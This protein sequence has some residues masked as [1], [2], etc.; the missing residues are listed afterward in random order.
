MRLESPLCKVRL[1]S[2]NAP[3]AWGFFALLCLWVGC[4]PSEKTQDDQPSS[5]TVGRA[6]EWRVEASASSSAPTPGSVSIER[7]SAVKLWRQ[8]P[9][10]LN[11][12]TVAKSFFPEFFWSEGPTAQGISLPAIQDSLRVHLP[13]SADG[14]LAL[15]AGP[16]FFQLRSIESSNPSAS[17]KLGRGLFYSS[18][19]F[20]LAA[21]GTGGSD[22]DSHWQTSRVDEFVIHEGAHT[23]FSTRYEVKLSQTVRSVRDTGRWLEF[24]DADGI[25]VLRM[26]Y[27]LAR[28]L[29]GLTHQGTATLRGVVP[30]KLDAD[31]A[32]IYRLSAS[33]L[34]VELTVP[35]AGMQSPVLITTSLTSPVNMAYPRTQHTAT[36]LPSGKVLVAGGYS[37]TGS[38]QEIDLYDPVTRTW[39][40]ATS[41]GVP[42]RNHTATLLPSGKVLFVGGVAP[43]TTPLDTAE[44]YNPAPGIAQ[45]STPVGTQDT[46][47]ATHTATLL[48]NGGVLITGGVKGGV[49]K[50]T[51]LYPP[52]GGNWES[53]GDLTTARALHTATLLQSGKVLVIGGI[54]HGSNKLNSA[55]LYNPNT[56]GWESFPSI[57]TSRSEHTAVL[58]ASDTVLVIGGIG[59]ANNSVLSSCEM[60]D[61]Q[62][63][64]AQWASAAPLST[65]RSGHIATLL[66][67]SKVLITG[68]INSTGAPVSNVTLYDPATGEAAVSTTPALTPRYGHTATLLPSGEVLVAGGQGLTGSLQ[69]SQTVSSSSGAW[70]DV[71][72]MNIGRTR[73]TTTLLPSGKALAA[74]GWDGVFFLNSARLYTPKAPA[75][76]EWDSAGLMA[77]ARAGHT[78]TLLPSGKVLVA[79][80]ENADG[81]L[82]TAELYDPTSDSWSYTGSLNTARIEHTA[83][84]LASGKVLVVGGRESLSTPDALASA[85]LY[86]PATG[87]WTTISSPHA[88]RF[89]HTSTLLLP[90][91]KV[92]LAGGENANGPLTT[93][94]LY[95]PKDNTWSQ[96]NPLS[97]ARINHTATPLAS[98]EVLIVGGRETHNT[99]TALAT[100]ERYKLSTGAWTTIASSPARYLH[101]ATRLPHGNVLITGGRDENGVQDTAHM[102]NPA[103]GEWNPV[104]TAST[105]TARFNHTATLLSSGEVLLVGGETA[106]SQLSSAEL[107]DALGPTNAGAGNFR[108]EIQTASASFDGTT[109]EFNLTGTRFWTALEGSGGGTRA[110]H[111]N[112]PVFTL[113][114]GDGSGGWPV[115]IQDLTTNSLTASIETTT[116]L[117]H[118]LLFVQNNALT[119]GQMVLLDDEAPAVP[120]ITA[121]TGWVTSRSFKLRGTKAPNTVVNI[122][123]GTKRLG[124]LDQLTSSTAWEVDLTLDKD[125]IYSVHATATD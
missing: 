113:R 104:S 77:D 46:D 8:T 9:D 50:T 22:A 45:P 6:Q 97:T 17:R 81:S 120:K 15:A 30:E 27:P 64:P 90:S 71:S 13:T 96:I 10:E 35:L 68:G 123:Q 25:P 20:R 65:Q 88:G 44:V 58:L 1:S 89:L 85:E 38:L 59:G 100:A 115:K 7:S 12:L 14:E 106:S 49:L 41:M 72:P 122:Y 23:P 114:A 95:D 111:T 5:V 116:P 21:Q 39:S 36:L 52:G 11:T 67:S 55:E 105:P 53:K 19:H 33:A 125:G 40:P 124:G 37:G 26:H 28:D 54:G 109:L 110:S 51:V 47:R 93:A 121:P 82:S 16:H 69:S 79:G 56:G 74:G 108:P 66:P 24:L 43:N 61:L 103:A 75:S 60:Y 84:L 2:T 62:S 87:R 70:V 42:R 99:T 32:P 48:P 76:Q 119:D 63:A 101:T 29:M 80:G 31:N 112:L 92:L 94:A 118:Y 78:A 86:D 57:S 117:S 3:R 91:G 83:T 18:H 34:S 4:S 102:Y 107:F 73:H 98:D